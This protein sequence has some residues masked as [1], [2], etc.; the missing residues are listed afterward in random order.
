[1]AALDRTALHALGSLTL[2]S[3]LKRLGERLAQE[4]ATSYRE[5]GFPFESRWFPVFHQLGAGGPSTA[6]ELAS[7][8]GCTHTA[9]ILFGNEMLRAGLVQVGPAA[10]DRRKRVLELSAEGRALFRR[11]LHLWGDFRKATDQ[12][13]AEAGGDLAGALDR[14]ERALDRQPLRE[15]LPKCH[16]LQELDRVEVVPYDPAERAALE[17]L[18]ETA[19]KGGAVLEPEEEASLAHPERNG[20]LRVLLA[21]LEGTVAGLC[22]LR[23]SSRPE[24]LLL[25]V[26]PRARR[27]QVGRRLVLACVEES[28]R[29]GARALLARMGPGQGA[30]HR[31]FLSLGFSEAGGAGERG[32]VRLRLDLGNHPPQPLRTRRER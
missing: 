8:I 7:R 31:L 23:R 26:S 20:G 9:V 6:T 25:A 21:R 29:D 14:M 2:P 13:L 24:I 30:A 17:A 5:H 22:V 4:V 16:T 19:R 12:M 10:P 32:R 3:R 27:R 15:R 11:L 28:H 18:L 1:M